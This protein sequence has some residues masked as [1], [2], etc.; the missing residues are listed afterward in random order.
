MMA[1]RPLLVNGERLMIMGYDLYPME[2]LEFKRAFVREAIES[3]YIIFFGHDPAVAAG[4]IRQDG[5]KLSVEPLN[6]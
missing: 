4:F 5:K 1:M 3:E 2:T 6:P